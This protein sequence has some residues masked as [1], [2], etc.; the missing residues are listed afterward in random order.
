MARPAQLQAD[1][2]NPRLK[3]LDRYVGIPVVATM[4][5]RRRLR[6]ARPLPADWHTIGIFLTAGIGDTVIASGIM[7]DLRNARPDVRIV[8]FVTANNAEFARLLTDPD[9]IVELPVRRIPTAIRMVRDERCDVI[10]DLTAWRRYDAVLSMLSGAAWTVGR[11]TPHQFRHYGYDV[12]V[13]HQRDHELDND[14]RL[15]AQLGVASSSA[16]RLDLPASATSPMSTPYVVF[17]MWPGGAN[18]A[19]RSWPSESWRTLARAMNA[20]GFAVVLTGG[21]GDVRVNRETADRWVSDGIRVQS[22]AGTDWSQSVVWLAFAAGVISVNT[23]VMHV[24]AALGTPTIALNGPTSG[25]RWG[26]LGPH[27]RCVASPMIPT[28]YLDLGFEHDE[29]YRDCMRAITVDMVL[30]AWN[31]LRAEAE[32]AGRAGA[33]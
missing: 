16:P 8:L 32:A 1:R 31:D 15:L 13:D 24:A 26:P 28:G 11:R 21:P 12:V 9:A 19:E 23:G 10:L 29:R 33:P 6:G 27:T 17:H 4:S 20:L 14:R 22:A 5:L 2:G 7:H 3:F 18:F 25:V 30:A